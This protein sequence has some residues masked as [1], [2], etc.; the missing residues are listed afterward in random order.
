MWARRVPTHTMLVVVNFIVMSYLAL[1]LKARCS[2]AN[3][4]SITK[5]WQWVKA[6]TT[7]TVTPTISS[8]SIIINP[9]YDSVIP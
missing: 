5:G 7:T 1:V 3:A 9:P 4:A 2:A 6:S 8:R